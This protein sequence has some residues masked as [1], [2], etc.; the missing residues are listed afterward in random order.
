L[1]D[2]YLQRVYER[3]MVSSKDVRG[4]NWELLRQ[5][6]EAEGLYFEPLE[7]PDGDAT[8]A[9][10]WVARDEVDESRP[11]NSRFLNIA[12]PWG[13][14]RLRAWT[15]FVETRYVDADGFP[16]PPDHP[17]ARPL[18]LIPLALYGLDHPKI[19]AVLVDFRDHANPQRREMSRRVLNDITRNVLSLS[20]Y[21]DLHYFLGRTI[22]GFVTGRRGMDVN[23]PSRLRSY[24]QLKLLLSLSSSMHPDL[25]EETERLVERVSMNPLQ[26]D[27]DIEIALAYRSYE[28]LATDARA[29]GGGLAARLE[30]D[31]RAEYRRLEHGA[32]ARVFL[33]MATVATAG[34]YRHREPVPAPV[35][36]AR[37]DTSRRLAY[38]ERFLEEVLASTPVIEVVWDIEEVRR[39]LRFISEHADRGDGALV[40]LAEAVFD[41]TDDRVTRRIILDALARADSEASRIALARI[42]RRADLELELRALSV[43]PSG[44]PAPGGQP[45]RFEAELVPSG[46]TR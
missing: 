37:L 45:L 18:E 6:A 31:R 33:R 14:A 7:M 5:R 42:Q 43:Q 25:V 29:P 40:A 11:F 41:Q 13:D 22:Y 39:S 3:D 4:H 23:Q 44:A 20:P 26:N 15:G 2:G 46:A 21:G 10:V 34:L 17:G 32:T 36:L 12:S 9:L 1:D 38:H 30:R 24:S 28:A 19:P 8:H 35:Q 27:R 16:V